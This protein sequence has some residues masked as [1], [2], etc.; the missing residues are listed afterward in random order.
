MR[1]SETA[2]QNPVCTAVIFAKIRHKRQFY[3]GEVYDFTDLV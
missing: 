2:A 3:H 1:T